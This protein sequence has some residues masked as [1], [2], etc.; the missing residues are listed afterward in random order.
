MAIDNISKGDELLIDYTLPTDEYW[1]RK[2]KCEA[3]GFEC[4][5]Q[6]CSQEPSARGKSDER[7]ALIYQID[8]EIYEM[9]ENT[10]EFL[11]GIKACQ[12]LLDL[13]REEF[14]SGGDPNIVFR[15]L[16]DQF[17]GHLFLNDKAG[18]QALVE[19]LEREGQ[20]AYGGKDTPQYRDMVRSVKQKIWD[21]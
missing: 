21:L 5:C 17:Q 6:V 20:V 2:T 15:T 14:P 13:I 3:H 16:Y 8:D 10:G 18:A 4:Q 1:A 7:R 11:E 9:M 19:R 12:E